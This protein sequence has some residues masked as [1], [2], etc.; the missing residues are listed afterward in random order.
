MHLLT[1]WRI[2]QNLDR[3]C[4]TQAVWLECAMASFMAM[5]YIQIELVG[6]TSYFH[7]KNK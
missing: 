7:M 4:E 6:I 2:F 3:H 5:D 1:N